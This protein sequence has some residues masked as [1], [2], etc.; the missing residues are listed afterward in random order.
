MLTRHLS[1]ARQ[2]KFSRNVIGPVLFVEPSGSSN[3]GTLTSEERQQLRDAT[4]AHR[5]RL[6]ITPVLTIGPET[7]G[8]ILRKAGRLSSTPRR[9]A[10]GGD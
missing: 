2:A 9:I 1:A 4:I 5:R 3:P 6:G 10:T 7:L 8:A